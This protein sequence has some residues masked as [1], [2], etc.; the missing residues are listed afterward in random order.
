MAIDQPLTV[1]PKDDKKKRNAT[2]AE[3]D[4][5][6]KE[7]EQTHTDIHTGEKVSLSELFGKKK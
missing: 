2:K 1:Y 6:Q 3:I 4:A 5:L 7:W